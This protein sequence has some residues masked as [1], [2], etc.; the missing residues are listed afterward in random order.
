MTDVAATAALA[1]NAIKLLNL[2]ELMFGMLEESGIALDEVVE[3]RAKA[4]REGRSN[5]NNEEM[6]LL[7]SKA[8]RAIDSIE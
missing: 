6:V 2:A 7:A 8:R 1:M 4:Q 5:L 3:M